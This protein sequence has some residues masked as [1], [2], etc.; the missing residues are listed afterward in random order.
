MFKDMKIGMRLGLGF[1]LLVLLM[2][3]LIWIG[4]SGMMHVDEDMERIVKVNMVRINHVSDMDEA[5]MN[6]SIN[7]RNILYNNIPEK[8]QEYSQRIAKFREEYNNSFKKA[9]E[10]TTKTDSKAWEII[11]KLKESLTTSRNLNNKVIE[12]AMANKDA[13]ANEHMSK[14]A[15]PAE[16]VVQQ[17]IEDLLKHNEERN[18]IRHEEA[19]ASYESSRNFMLGLGIVAILLAVGVALYLTRG[20]VGPLNDAVAVNNRLAA[21]DLTVD[22]QT[23]RHDEIGLMLAAMKKM[24]AKLAQVMGD[25]R[26]AADQVATGSQELS[27]T[28]QNVSQGASEQAAT[29]EEISSSM[30]EMTSTVAQSADSARQTAAIAK[31]SSVEAEKGGEAVASTET[32]MQT[33]ASKIAIIEEIARLA[34]F[35]A[36]PVTLP[37]G[38]VATPRPGPEVR[39]L[40]KARQL[41]E[42]LGFFEVITYSFQ[43]DRLGSLLNAAGTP[44]AASRPQPWP[45]RPSARS[46]PVRPE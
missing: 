40:G 19:V 20:I 28:A 18:N 2:V 30:E 3:V 21:G 35:D 27:A 45:S 11:E 22:I 6:I 16:R 5:I 33:I 36:I 41:L 34:G 4:I 38:V 42:G 25:V 10:L 43:P 32:A 7:I 13:E 12:L 9:E 39:L 24:V 26:A 29:V 15:A 31:K 1:G 44:A 46:M 8:R 14:V 23:D 17:I 37:R